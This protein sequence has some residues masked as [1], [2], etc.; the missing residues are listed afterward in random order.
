METGTEDAEKFA[1]TKSLTAKNTVPSDTGD[2]LAALPCE[3]LVL[4]EEAPQPVIRS[5]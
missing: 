1:S 3:T 5:H 4:P 2:G